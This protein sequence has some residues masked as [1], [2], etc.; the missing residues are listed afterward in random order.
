M[1][2]R[3]SCELTGA[4]RATPKNLCENVPEIL[5]GEQFVVPGRP[6][7]EVVYM[8]PIESP[9]N[10]AAWRSFDEIKELAEAY[11]SALADA[12]AAW[13]SLSPAA[14][15]QVRAPGKPPLS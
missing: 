3:I 2:D 6:T 14:Q 1:C 9:P 13:K 7:G 5:R 8:P 15:R 11:W 4:M 12:E 10:I